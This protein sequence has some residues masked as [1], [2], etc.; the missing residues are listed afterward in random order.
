VRERYLKR[1][2]PGQRLYFDE[3]SP[4]S[5]ATVVIDTNDPGAA[6]YVARSDKACEQREVDA[7]T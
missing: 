4:E 3:A 7:G 1:Y 2:V 5:A 6:A